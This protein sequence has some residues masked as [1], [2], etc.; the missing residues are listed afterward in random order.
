[1]NEYQVND[2]VTI[3]GKGRS[4]RA[5][6]RLLRAIKSKSGQEGWMMLDGRGSIRYYTE[7]K[8]RKMVKRGE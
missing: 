7:D 5:W 8:I 1:M 2:Y 3:K 6:H 4:R